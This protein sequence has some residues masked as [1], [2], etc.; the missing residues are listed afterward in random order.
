MSRKYI[1]YTHKYLQCVVNILRRRNIMCVIIE[2]VLFVASYNNIRVDANPHYVL[3]YR[4][5]THG[6][7]CYI[8]KI[9]YTTAQTN[10]RFH[11]VS[12]TFQR[13]R[14]KESLKMLR[15]L[16][17]C[18]IRNPDSTRCIVDYKFYLFLL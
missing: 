13:E 18:F 9:Y 3:L 17:I 16:G 8:Y 7:Q 2:A 10:T 11:N 4:W 5:S 14:E 15:R 1:I 6:R 12:H